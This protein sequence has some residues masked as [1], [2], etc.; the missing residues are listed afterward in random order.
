MRR[1]NAAP[2]GVAGAEYLGEYPGM[3]WGFELVPMRVLGRHGA[4]RHGRHEQIAIAHIIDQGFDDGLG[5]KPA[6]AQRRDRAVN[7]QDAV[8]WDAEAFQDWHQ[9]G[10]LSARRHRSLDCRGR[11]RLDLFDQI[12]AA[13]DVAEREATQ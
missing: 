3:R 12:E 7:D 8:L 2:A 5:S 11:L 9:G 1:V 13:V 6:P 4:P 10:G